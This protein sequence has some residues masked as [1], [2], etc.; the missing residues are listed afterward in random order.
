MKKGRKILLG[1]LILVVLIVGVVYVSD[2]LYDVRSYVREVVA[3]FE[4]SPIPNILIS[5]RH[6]DGNFENH[7]VPAVGALTFVRSGTGAVLRIGSEEFSLNA[8]DTVCISDWAV[9]AS[10]VSRGDVLSD[11]LCFNAEDAN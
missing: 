4:P 11:K 7:Q 5:I 8:T 9:P 10:L 3:T 1:L 6:A 2:H